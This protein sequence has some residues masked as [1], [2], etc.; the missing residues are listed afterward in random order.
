MLRA[1]LLLV[2]NDLRLFFRDPIALLLSFALPIALVGIFGF[3]MGA[4]SG[5]GGGGLQP[6]DVAVRDEDGSPASAAFVQA[7]RESETVRPRFAK[8]GEFTREQLRERLDEGEDSFA[9]VIPAGFGD[10]AD[11]LLLRDPGRDI[12]ARMVQMGLLAALFEAKGGD[13]AWELSRRALDQAG[14]P[15]EWSGRIEGLMGPFRLGLEGLFA[16]ADREGRLDAAGGQDPLAFMERILPIATEDVVPA[17]RDRQLTYMVSH[18]VSGMTVM[19]LMFTLVG[20]ARTLLSERDQGTL[21]RLLAAPI[22]PRAILLG[23]F[24]MSVLL[25]LILIVVLYAFAA[26]V[27]K[28]DVLSRWDTLLFVSL[29]TSIACTAFALAIASWAKTDKQADGVSTLI[30]LGMSA[31]G[32]AWMPTMVMPPAAQAAARFTLT[33]WSLTGYQASLWYGKHWTEPEVLRPVGVVLGIA[34]VLGFLAVRIFRRRWL[35]G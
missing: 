31:L 9:L 16:D 23:K 1:A 35:S 25:G 28:V 2:R 17:G 14:L 30:I 22:D 6:V 8:E 13:A 19:M 3:I 34:L 32:G 29:A 5:G 10:G 20:A 21:R 27:F 11:L 15:P 7:L 4:M 12:E 26:L 18:A 24:L 33:H